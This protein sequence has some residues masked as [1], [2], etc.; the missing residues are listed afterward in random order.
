MSNKVIDLDIK[1]HTY[2]VFDDILNIKFFDPN[3]N[4][5]DEKS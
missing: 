1:D 3:N 4:K 2:Y 5:I